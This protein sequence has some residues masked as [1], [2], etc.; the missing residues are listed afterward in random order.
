MRFRIIAS[1]KRYRERNREK[2]TVLVYIVQLHAVQALFAVPHSRSHASQDRFGSD[3]RTARPHLNSQLVGSPRG[4]KA[5]GEPA[6][7]PIFEVLRIDA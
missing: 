6:R 4:D 5:R 1:R 2:F 7:R 3:R